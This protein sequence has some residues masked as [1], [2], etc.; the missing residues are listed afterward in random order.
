MDERLDVWPD[1]QSVA[2]WPE[3][4]A[5]NNAP[6]HCCC[7]SATTPRAHINGA[8]LRPSLLD[9]QRARTDGDAAAVGASLLG[10]SR[11]R[12]PIRTATTY[13]V[14]FCVCVVL[15]AVV[16][17]LALTVLEF[18]PWPLQLNSPAFLTAWLVAAVADACGATICLCLIVAASERPCAAALWVALCLAGG[19]PAICVYLLVRLLRHGTLRLTAA[20]RPS[21]TAVAAAG[22]RCRNAVDRAMLGALSPNYGL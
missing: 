16:G 5:A 9:M 8:P 19:T 22:G 6:P 14:A 1:A 2:S 3:I 17:V 4:A 15:I 10:S 12:Q 11:R 18:P 7:T 20:Q 21:L 13:V